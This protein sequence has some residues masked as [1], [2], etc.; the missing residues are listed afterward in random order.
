ML[1]LRPQR[2]QLPPPVFDDVV[3][4]IATTATQRAAR[5]RDAHTRSYGLVIGGALLTLGALAVPLAGRD[6][7]VAG[8]RRRRCPVAARGA[9]VLS[10]ALGDSTA[11]AML[12]FAGATYAFS[13]GVVAGAPGTGV[14]SMGR[15]NLLLG[16]AALTLAGVLGA[17]LVGD[18]LAVFVGL[19]ATGL[20]GGTAALLTVLTSVSPHGAAA[21]T[22]SVTMGLAPMLPMLALRLARL[23]LPAVPADAQDISDD[24][25]AVPGPGT[26]DRAEAA[27]QYLTGLVGACSVVTAAS[28]VLLTMTGRT[29]ARILGTIIAAA[30]L[31]RARVHWDRT[32]RLFLLGAG[33]VGVLAVL[34]SVLDAA[35]SSNRLLAVLALLIVSGAVSIAIAL[36]VPGRPISPYGARVVD[37]IEV[38][39][40]VSVIP[41][42]C[43]VVGLYS[44]LRGWAG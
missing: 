7:L 29:D 36:L 4:A 37:I 15:T 20:L 26:G 23:P 18:Y 39:L 38:L 41:V 21:L 6:R 17:G 5:W 40:L 42:A 25:S 13:A 22:A 19:A 8:H 35:G 32:Q 14:G 31:L 24:M 9:A 12:G 1:H 44:R 28:L 10:R 11:G 43:A 16:C 33:L 27:E 30:L 2:T 3:D 34:I